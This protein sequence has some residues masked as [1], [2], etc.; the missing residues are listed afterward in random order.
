MGIQI[1][2]TLP[3]CLMSHVSRHMAGQRI[4][5][6][7]AGV[8]MDAPIPALVALDACDMWTLAEETFE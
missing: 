2:S 3:R 7:V 4:A 8:G 6:P 5:Q 1:G